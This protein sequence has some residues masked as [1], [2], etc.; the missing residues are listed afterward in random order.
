MEIK[1]N[2]YKIL[3]L[4]GTPFLVAAYRLLFDRDPDA[5]GHEYYLNRLANG[6]S[7]EE[8]IYELSISQEAKERLNIGELPHL[9]DMQFI[10]EIYRLILVREPDPTGRLHYLRQL[11]SGTKRKKI[12][13][14]LIAS[15][16]ARSKHLGVSGLAE[17]IEIQNKS[18][19]LLS[20]FKNQ[21]KQEQQL[22]ALLFQINGS[23]DRLCDQID[24]H[25]KQFASIGNAI[26][27]ELRESK[28]A[29]N[30]I[31]NIEF[32]KEEIN[33]T[34]K[35]ISNECNELLPNILHRVYF[36]NY[37]PYSD[38][39]LHYLDTWKKELPGYKIIKWGK[40]NVD[41][42]ANEWMRRSANANDPVFLS[43]YARWDALK[44]YGGIYLDADC[45]VLNGQIFNALV[46]ELRNSDEYDAFVG[47]EEFNNGHPTAQTIAAKKGSELVEFMHKMYSET[48][49]GPLWHWRAE[50]GL[51][52]PQLISLYFREH[53]LTESKGFPVQL[54]EPIIIGRVKIYPQEYFSPKFTTTGKKLAVSNNTCIYHLFANLNVADV[55]PE[56]EKHRKSP[57]LFNE[58]CAYLRELDL[59][60]N[61]NAITN[62][63]NT[64]KVSKLN[65]KKGL[66]KLHR[67]Y[68]GFDGKPDPYLGYLKT[69]QELLPNYEIYHWDAS[70]LPI[71]NCYFS[72]L[73]FEYKDHAFLSDYFRWWILKE[74]GGVYLDADVEIINGNNFEMLISELE[75]TTDFDAFIGIDSKIDGWYTAHSMASK[76]NSSI[77]KF[78]CET[79]ESL[80]HV[81]MWRRK[82]FYFMAP[83][84]TS[85]YFASNG[86][87]IDGMGSYSGLDSPVV[88]AG[89]KI[90]PQEWFSPIRPV[91]KDGIAGFDI[92][93]YTSNTCIS[94]HFSCSWH[95]SDSIY[96]NEI[97][98]NKNLSL[99]E[100]IEMLGNRK[101][102][103]RK[104]LF[105]YI[106]RQK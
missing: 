7:K 84:L 43:E 89:V 14:A 74:H 85:L 87:N 16:E 8:I 52:G 104:N 35:N 47:V 77:A 28:P 30:K 22:R 2:I 46:E 42:T 57:M 55:D 40:N 4:S 94:H 10:E 23:T 38:P 17:L 98:S 70:N 54:K 102:N 103:K 93:S 67:I 88:I 12:I 83:Q 106:W 39:F 24:G 9:N 25:Y 50:R 96:N 72:R 36:E 76:P 92:D 21:K 27:N 56:A 11:S 45:E 48:L 20:K 97:K 18:K 6:A 99:K 58:Y 33:K 73:M 3:L 37:P 80:G 78:M 53:G 59:K 66:R 68:F 71:N 82:I 95:D 86:W 90:Y 19:N 101:S 51:I 5:E 44:N 63:L 64:N 34:H 60:I 41:T 32:N 105:Q 69:W 91:V 15:S 79:Y 100:K 13:N 61:S 1:P 75:N 65:P 81:S 49:S 26:I 62:S 31:S 29:F